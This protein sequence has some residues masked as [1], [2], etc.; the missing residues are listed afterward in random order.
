MAFRS[1]RGR[2]TFPFVQRDSNFP[3]PGYTTSNPFHPRSCVTAKTRNFACF[4]FD[5]TKK[6]HGNFGASLL[7][8]RVISRPTDYTL[9]FHFDSFPLILLQLFLSLSSFIFAYNLNFYLD[10]FR[11]KST[12]FSRAF[13]IYSRRHED[14]IQP[15]PATGRKWFHTMAGRDENGGQVTRRDSVGISKEGEYQ[16]RF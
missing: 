8:S 15:D 14:E 9:L 1:N 2:L 5:S 7:L 6:L 10:L 11:S 13:L 4:V 3:S 16:A 12:F